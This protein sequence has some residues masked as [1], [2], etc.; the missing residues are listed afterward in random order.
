MPGPRGDPDALI[1]TR[2]TRAWTR[3][4]RTLVLGM[5]DAGVRTLGVPA[6]PDHDFDAEV[7]LWHSLF[8]AFCPET[9]R[10]LSPNPLGLAAGPWLHGGPLDPVRDRMRFG[11]GR[12]REPYGPELATQDFGA[13]WTALVL[14][15]LVCAE[16]ELA[17]T[18]WRP[19]DPG[20]WLLERA[21]L[22]Q[23][24]DTA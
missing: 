4:P 2:G 9:G 15:Q 3:D 7:G 11:I 20:R 1:D 21:G 8:R 18:A 13:R 16:D 24:R 23:A 6:W 19:L 5:P 12:P 14:D 17:L 22:V 10:Y